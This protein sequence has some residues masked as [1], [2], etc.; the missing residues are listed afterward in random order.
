MQGIIYQLISTF[1]FGTSNA[2]WRK[3]IDKLDVEEAIL[4]RTIHSLL[5]FVVLIFVFDRPSLI[6][7]GLSNVNYIEIVGFAFIISL[8]SFFGLFFFNKAL[9]YSPTGIVATTATISFLI[10]QFISFI[11][12]KES[13][14]VKIIIP[15][16][17][18]IIMIIVS[19]Y[20]SIRNY[21]LSKGILYGI[22]AAV[23]WGATLPL[24]SIPAK[25]IGFIETS[26]IL[27]FSVLIM[28]FSIFKWYHKKKISILNFKKFYKY[29]LLLGLFAGTGV[30]FMN[31]AY[32]EIPVHI[33]G[34]IASSTHIITIII[35]WVLF[36]EKMK[37]HQILAALIAF[38]GIFYLTAIIQK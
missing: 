38:V 5:F 19:D 27:E 8:I 34:A 36:N 33:A 6:K 17:I 35:S 20:E 3:P 7:E 25:Q 32:T 28:S 12:L 1:A 4:Y 13:F 23:F 30:L 2:L 24:L 10:V 31:L 18:F 26:F 29:F 37:K 15:L 21:K 16:I 11:V 9:K 14:S 22:L